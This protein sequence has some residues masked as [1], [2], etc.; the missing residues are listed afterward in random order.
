MTRSGRTI[1]AILIGSYLQVHA[2]SL[3]AEPPSLWG[4]L[5]AGE[6]P[7]GFQVL[8]IVDPGRAI[9]DRRT[10]TGDGAAFVP[11]PLQVSIWYPAG[12]G[13]GDPMRFR[14][15]LRL[16]LSERGTEPA[17][18][19]RSPQPADDASIFCR[20]LM[21]D[22]CSPERSRAQL[23]SLFSEAVA[24]RREARAAAGRFP[25]VLFA[26]GNS[27]AAFNHAL[28]AELVA[29]HGFIVATTPS[30]TRILARGDVVEDGARDLERVLDALFDRPGVDR[31]RLALLGFSLGGNSVGKLL[32]RHPGFSAVVSLDSGFGSTFGTPALRAVPEYAMGR[33]RPIA[34]LHASRGS[35]RE[36]LGVI[37]SFAYAERYVARL[38]GLEHFN[39]TSRGML[40]GRLSAQ[41][42]EPRWLIGGDAAKRGYE[43]VGR[44]VVWFLRGEVLGHE[45][46]R[47]AL[48]ALAGPSASLPELSSLNYTPGLRPAVPSED[49]FLELIRG[50]GVEAG[51]DLYQRARKR[52]PQLVLFAEQAVNRLAYSEYLSH[53]RGEEAVALFRLITEAYPASANAWD[54]LGEGLETLGEIDAAIRSYEKSLALDAE[55]RQATE[56]LEALRRKAR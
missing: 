5:E 45:A 48:R 40:A 44:L 32:L 24:A 55:N 12:D 19:S 42:F 14:D 4:E 22:L 38:E 11:R 53:G 6:W 47:S 51:V 37:E 26:Q 27:D 35:E 54:S 3:R 41:A 25:L 2:G 7:I 20:F 43:T 23:E 36:D 34:I 9:G 28:L 16:A 56:A 13:D 33:N 30:P 52:N 10:S 15:Y 29:S 21:G 49:G 50:N 46:S 39:F 17:A 8:Q 18:T 1:L 31:R